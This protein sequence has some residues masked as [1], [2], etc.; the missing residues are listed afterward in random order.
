MHA[1]LLPCMIFNR[2]D[3]EITMMSTMTW[4]SAGTA[5]CKGA[6]LATVR[7]VCFVTATKRQLLHLVQ[8]ALPGEVAT[9]INAERFLCLLGVPDLALQEGPYGHRDVH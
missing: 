3:H 4:P 5:E 6:M 9:S 2:L 1:Q 8:A 7:D